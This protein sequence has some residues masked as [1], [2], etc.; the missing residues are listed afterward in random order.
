MPNRRASSLSLISGFIAW[1]S[2]A[3]SAVSC[4]GRRWRGVVDSAGRVA[5]EVTM[6]RAGA[7]T[8]ARVTAGRAGGGVEPFT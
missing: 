1:I 2:S 3:R 6:V 7:E 4:T 8:A 5:D